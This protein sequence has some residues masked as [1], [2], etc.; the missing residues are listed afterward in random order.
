MICASC[1]TQN[2]AGRKFCGNCGT[3]LAVACPV[4]GSPNPPTV[5]FCGECGS[6][7]SGANGPPSSADPGAGISEAAAASPAAPVAERRLVSVLFADLVGFTTLSEARD[8]EE[9][10]D[11][12]SRYFDTAREII[13]R[14]SGTVEKFIGDAV[15][16]VWGTPTAHEDDAERAVR[17][18]LE[19]VE[20]IHLLG[21]A[22][23]APDLQLRAGVLTG[24]AAV[25]LGATNQGMVAGDLVNT[26]S[27]LQSVA[28]PGSVLVGEPTMRTASEAIVFE[29]A[30]EQML[31]G[32]VAPVPAYRA[33]RVVARRGGSGRSEQLEPPFVGR[34]AELR[35]L[36]DF[37]HGSA[38]ERGVRL[39][40]VVGQGGIGKTRLAWEFQK[41]LDGISEP[42]LW[43]QGRSP[44]YG[45]GISFWALGEMVRMRAGVGEGDDEA[46][47]RSRVAETVGRYA[48]DVNE[49][50]ELEGALLQLLGINDGR[51]RE[52]DALFLAWRSFWERLSETATVVLVFEDLQWADAGLLDFIEYL[53]AWSRG[54]P[55]YIVTLT[56]PELLD[57]RPTWGA[58]QRSFTSLGLGPL[59]EADMRLLLT[60]LVPGMPE[61]AVREIV[62][63]AEGIPLYAVETLR[64]L[65]NDGRLGQED[66]VLVV[67][68]ELGEI[69]IPESLHALI[70]AR[71]DALDPEERGLLQDAAVLGQS[72]SV[73]AVTAL[74]GG[75][76]ADVEPMLVRLVARELLVH[77]DDP[78]SP[79]RGQYGFVQSLVR[80]VAYGTLSRTDARSRHLDAARFFE[81]QDDGELAG[82]LAEHYLAAYRARPS[83][84]EGAA[85]A[86]QARVALR[87]AASRAAAVGAPGRAA[88]YLEQAIEVSGSP[89]EEL[90]LRLEA[91]RFAGDGGDFDAARAHAERGIELA[92]AAGD[93]SMRRRLIAH[94]GGVLSEGHLD[95]G[96]ALLEAEIGD[97]DLTP[98]APGYAEL[99]G[100]IGSVYMRVGRN[101]EAVTWSDRALGVPETERS[102]RETA[103]ILIT[104]GVAL[105]NLS[106]SAEATIILMGAWDFSRQHRLLGS[107]ARAAIN[108][109]YAL[110]PDDSRAA[111]QISREG[112]EI[113]RSIGN[114]WGSRYLLGNAAEAALE[115]GDWDWARAQLAELLARDDLSLLEQFHAGA[116]DLPFRAFRGEAL[117]AEL[118]RL[119]ALARTFSDPQITHG[120]GE[121]RMGVALGAG[122]LAEVC[123]VADA[124][125]AVPMWGPE[126][127]AGG[128]RAAIWLGDVARARHFAEAYAGRQGRRTDA[129]HRTNHAGLAALESRTGEARSL[130]REALGLWRDAGAL[131]SRAL[132]VIDMAVTGSLDA[133]DDRPLIEEARSFLDRVGARPFTARLD[134]ALE[135]SRARPGA[136][137]RAGSAAAATPQANPRPSG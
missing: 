64:M 124:Q 88:R 84:D 21:A 18:A 98:Q 74:H 53:L 62:D 33:L 87:G 39:V 34:D 76:E 42:I 80:E 19:L 3:R 71:M 96:L 13:G 35:L 116:V 103:E 16:A 105:A 41:Y 23:G 101:A 46:T 134:A 112:L 32:K 48:G 38:R 127:A 67:R 45:E 61:D 40:S 57:R 115:S 26:A 59:S 73:P 109:S 36:K 51:V 27:R 7:M 92:D 132:T 97:P 24:E 119:A 90:E 108:L 47:T 5:R 79:E 20:A 66:G 106:R 10:R 100:R 111:G 75:A 130:Y 78:R 104:R 44:S 135:A 58:G 9:V 29:P 30:G 15:M 77:D 113:A 107:A 65:V 1:G 136:V 95:E 52:R 118:E 43:H 22:V 4:C 6:G 68:G 14:Y 86:A 110:D 82:V 131:W 99:A 93:R 128:A 133:V 129:A 85:V 137:R 49:R 70:A 120:F 54:H 2:D 121:V 122:D 117:S 69:A 63:R 50:A 91:S 123:T 83:G 55:I 11:L 72:F 60:G 89:A 28:P 126:S 17:A 12:L 125:L 94:L 81:A 56:R 114:R 37:Y 102:V 25:T 31:K 8:A